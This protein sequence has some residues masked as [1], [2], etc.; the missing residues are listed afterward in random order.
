MS[1]ASLPVLWVFEVG[2]TDVLTENAQVPA[3][4]GVHTSVAYERVSGAVSLSLSV[5]IQQWLSCI[6]DALPFNCIRQEG[7]L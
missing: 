7:P 1:A 3:R 5:F 2:L 6:C 4:E